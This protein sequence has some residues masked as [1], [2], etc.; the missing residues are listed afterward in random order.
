MKGVFTGSH[1]MCRQ[2]KEIKPRAAYPPAPERKSGIGSICAA[3]RA[4][5]DR[6]GADRPAP[7]IIP[8][9]WPVEA[10]R[11][12]AGATGPA[13]ATVAIRPNLEQPRR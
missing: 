12:H 7:F 2:C 10:E 11:R 8:F 5:I 6:V 13:L 4:E 3:C 9:D 1:R